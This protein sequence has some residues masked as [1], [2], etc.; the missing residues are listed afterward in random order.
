RG[1]ERPAPRAA[2]R[3]LAFRSFDAGDFSSRSM[4]SPQVTVSAMEIP[5]GAP[6]DA[7]GKRWGWSRGTTAMT[8]AYDVPS[9][10]CDSLPDTEMK[11]NIKQPVKRLSLRLYHS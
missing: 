4:G 3:S 10:L 2:F 6:R 9:R 5:S 8:A 11:P 7:G 1:M